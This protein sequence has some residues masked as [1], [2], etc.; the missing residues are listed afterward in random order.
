PSVALLSQGNGARIKNMK[1]IL[2]VEDDQE[3]TRTYR[4]PFEE[5]GF[6]F[7]FAED[8][9]TAVKMI[10]KV[11]PDLIVLN[12]NIPKLNGVDILRYVRSH[13]DF[14]AVPVVVFSNAFMSE[15]AQRAAAEGANI[16]LL[17]SQCS[18]SQLIAV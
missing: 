8:G 14:K 9:L 11:R 1:K 5:V 17:K 18:P 16:G 3:I 12:L 15:M 7:E 13:K 2:F 10:S 4:K 6:Q